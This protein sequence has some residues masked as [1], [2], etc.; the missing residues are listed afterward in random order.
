MKFDTKH[1][2]KEI[3]EGTEGSG[4]SMPDIAS[5]SK[6]QLH[7]ELDLVGMSRI[8][9]PIVLTAVDGSPRQVL[10]Q[11]DAFVNIADPKAKGIHMS[12]LFLEIEEKLSQTPLSL[13]LLKKVLSNF[14]ESHQGLSDTALIRIHFNDFVKRPAL[15][16]DYSGWR[17]YPVFIS[18]LLKEG[19]YKFEMGVDVL[20]SSTC[21]CSAALARKLIQEQF[22]KDFKGTAENLSYESVL[23]WL[24]SEK[25]IVATPHSQRSRAEVLVDLGEG[26]GEMDWIA[27][28]DHIEGVLK[29]PVQAAVKRPDEQEFA[30]LNG[31]NLMFCEDAA[32]RIHKK[33]D[34][35]ES[36]Q[37]FYVKC[38]HMESLH[39]HDAVSTTTKGV[40]GG[41]ISSTEY[42]L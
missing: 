40:S 2:M 8:E 30:L 11:I 34:Q 29:T 13:G 15:K 7:G 10:A 17:K 1:P 36:V 27:L 9:A 6:T 5:Q 20:Y 3:G 37:D 25:G 28:V 33:L 26:S 39:P 4:T 23:E 12:R 31:Q 41:Y 38:I 19:Q 32:R 22:E 16:S 21:P 18:G 14:I 42:S 35:L 24:G